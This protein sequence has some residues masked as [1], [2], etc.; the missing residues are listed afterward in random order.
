MNI[1]YVGHYKEGTGWARAAIDYI[2]ALDSANV[3]VVCRNIP[4]TN[5]NNPV[6]ERILELENKPIENIDYCI[7]HVLPHYFSQSEK[8]KKNILCFVGETDT[9]KYSGWLSILQEAQE[10]W[11]PSQSNK[12]VLLNDGVNNVKVVPYAFNLSNYNKDSYK[13]ILFPASR[14][15]FKFYYIGDIN[16]RKNIDSIIRCYHS[17][18]HNDENVALVI[19]GS[20]HGID[21][22]Q[23]KENLMS[24]SNDIKKSL[25]IWR[26]ASE[27]CP[28]YF[29]TDFFSEN[30]ILSLHATC[31]CFINISH[32]EGWS[33]PS[34]ESMCF[35]NT[36]ICS[37]DGGTK[38]FIDTNNKNTGTLIDG[39]YSICNHSD[40]AFPTIFTGREHWFVPSE[41]DTKAAMRYYYENRNNINRQ[42]GLS[43]ASEYNYDNVAKIMIEE[44]TKEKA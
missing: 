16:D 6:P 3:N 36:P 20:K 27:F 18:F 22:R 37:N 35:G 19:K 10:V 23:L 17:E 13:N 25:R 34:F 8:F 15:A 42:D 11:V 30:E 44:L 9:V 5:K 12:A 4:L 2:L 38:D 40:P 14:D 39:V 43:R 7:Q 33:I 24:R 26:N 41:R 31:D 32:G 28:E 1:L 21:S 29:L